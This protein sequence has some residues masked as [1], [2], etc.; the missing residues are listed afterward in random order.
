MT[1]KKILDKFRTRPYPK[2]NLPSE[3]YINEHSKPLFNKN[4]IIDLKNL[5][6]YHCANETFKI[7]KFRSPIAVVKRIFFYTYYHNPT[8]R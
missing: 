3:F 7:L 6:Y 5:H 2:Q 4:K 8:T 1:G